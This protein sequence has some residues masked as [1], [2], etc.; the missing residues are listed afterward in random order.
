MESHPDVDY[1]TPGA[2]VHFVET[3]SS[4][5]QKLVQSVEHRPTAQTVGMLNR[6]INGERDLKKRQALL[7]TLE[8]VLEHP[9]GDSMTR[10]RASTTWNFNYAPRQ[11]FLN[12]PNDLLKAYRRSVAG[13]QEPS[14]SPHR[15]GR[16][17]SCTGQIRCGAERFSLVP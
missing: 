3:F 13:Q 11:A 4:Y 9:Q 7:A 16:N 14:T 12:Y 17:T 5:E 10:C 15:H 1:G 6:V 2:L 8:R